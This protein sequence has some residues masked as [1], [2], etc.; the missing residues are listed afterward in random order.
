MHVRAVFC[1]LEKW[2][3]TVRRACRDLHVF[4]GA[5]IPRHRAD[6]HSESTVSKC[7]WLRRHDS[8]ES[9]RRYHEADIRSPLV[10]TDLMQSSCLAH[11]EECRSSEGLRT[12]WVCC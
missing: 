3:Y 4:E 12:L 9:V 11:E 1:A 8:A 6:I 2:N 10:V 7:V 5:V